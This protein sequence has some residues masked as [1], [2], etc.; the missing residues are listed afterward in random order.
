MPTSTVSVDVYDDDAAAI[1]LSVASLNLVEGL[2]T[3]SYT[4][5]LLSEPAGT[6]SIAPASNDTSQVQLSPSQVQFT[7]GTWSSPQ[8]ITVAAVDDA[9]KEGIE[10]FT[11]SHTASSAVDA[12]YDG[13][14]VP[15][16][17]GSVIP[18]TVF[19][20]DWPAVVVSVL[21]VGMIEGRSETFTVYLASQPTAAVTISCTQVGGAGLVIN[22]SSLAF[23]T[24]NFQNP[25]TVTISVT[26]NTESEGTRTLQLENSAISADPN[27]NGAAARFAPDATLSVIVYDDDDAGILIVGGPIYMHEGETT[28]YTVV[29]TSAPTADVYISIRDIPPTLHVTTSLGLAI[30]TLKFS[31]SDWHIPQNVSVQAVDDSVDRGNM[32]AE[33]L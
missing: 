8:Q 2:L 26:D 16:L 25:Q 7:A 5:H 11:V 24:S 22:P 28:R 10:H 33:Y 32:Y 30:P 6:V 31:I 14:L 1:V 17:P 4:I 9:L 21:T 29:L 12:A 15:F 3:A 23:T 20:N 18:V 13:S 27:Y 19:D